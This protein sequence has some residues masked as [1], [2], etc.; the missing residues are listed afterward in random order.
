MV[1]PASSSLRPLWYLCGL[2]LLIGVFCRFKGLG[3]APLTV[4]EYYLVRSI[5]NVLR[6]GVPLFSCGGYYMRG[7]VLQYLSAAEQA[8]GM[9]PE[10]A[11]RLIS[12]LCSLATLPAAFLIGRRLRGSLVG[13]LTVA[14]LSLSVWEIEIGRFGRMYAPFQA[15]FVWYLVFFLR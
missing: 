12:A 2:A 15:V 4:D 11:P 7:L 6:S 1:K 14:L 8:A 10:L 13:I 5:Q 9:S 3:T